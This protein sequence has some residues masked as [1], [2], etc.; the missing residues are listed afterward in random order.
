MLPAVTP[1]RRKSA[2]IGLLLAAAIT[3]VPTVLAQ[4]D[5]GGNTVHIHFRILAHPFWGVT[6]AAALCAAAAHIAIRRKAL[7]TILRTTAAT[8]ALITFTLLVLGYTI[9]FR[10]SGYQ[11]FTAETEEALI[12]TSD[13]FEVIARDFGS[14]VDFFIRSKQG[15]ASRQATMSLICFNDGFTGSSNPP[16][17]DPGWYSDRATFVGTG[18]VQLFARSGDTKIVQFDARTLGPKKRSN[19]CLT[20][21]ALR[22]DL[23]QPG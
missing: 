9:V 1:G 2:T 19:D 18:Q 16:D 4:A 21:S 7:R 13:Q 11:S 5:A 23:G 10:S 12:V 17:E 22:A 8:V 15:W 3:A 14:E 20:D 6:F